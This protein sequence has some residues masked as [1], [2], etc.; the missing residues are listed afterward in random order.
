MSATQMQ[1]PRPKPFLR[2]PD[3]TQRGGPRVF[4]IPVHRNFADAL[5]N[6]I[7]AMHGSDRLALAR[8][9]IL[10]PNNRAAR[11]ITDAFVRRAEAGLLMPR[12]VAVGDVDGDAPGLALDP[13]DAEP[14]PPAIDR[15]LR[16]FVLARLVQQFRAET[17]ARTDAAEAL[18]LAANLATTID[19]LQ[20][21]DIDPAALRSLDVAESL[22]VHWQKSLEL[23]VMLLDRWPQELAALGC[24]DLVERR[25]RLLRRQAGAWREH[26]PASMIIAAGVT[27]SAVA[28]AGLLHVVARLP[29]GMVVLPGVDLASPDDEW[30]SIADHNIES[31]P[32]HHLR[33]LLDRMDV[34]RRDVVRWRWGDGRERKA[35]RARAVSNAFAPARFTGKWETLP[36]QLRRLRGVRIGTF[37]TAADEAQG[38]AIALRGALETSGKTAAL[39]TP[40]RALA[41]RVAAHLKRWGID[42]DDSAGRPLSLTPAG[43][44]ILGLADAANAQFAPA[45]LLSLLKHPLVRAG[46]ERLA[47]LSGARALDFA[48]R[49]PQPAPGLAGLAAFLEGSGA[50]TRS[51][52]AAAAPWWRETAS[53]L[54][55]IEAAFI[56]PLAD[57]ASLLEIMRATIEALAGDAAWAGPDGRAAGT[58]F[59]ALIA[60]AGKGPLDFG[61]DALAPALRQIMSEV[62]VRPPQGGHPRIAILGLL[63]ARLQ[64]ADLMILGGLNEGVWPPDASPDPWLAPRVR[65]ELGLGGLDRRV[66][67]SAHDLAMAL[68][69]REVLLTRSARDARSPT[70]ASRFVL[71]LQAMLGGIDRDDDIVAMATAIDAANAPP[72]LSHRPAPRPS[73]EYRPKIVSVTEVDRLKSDPFGFYARR[74]LRLRTL[75]PVEASPSPAWRGTLVHD[76]FDKWFKEDALDPAKLNDRVVALFSEPGMHPVLRALWQPRLTEAMTKM[77]ELVAEDAS[78]GRTVIAT[79]TQGSIVVA[80]VRL[81][82]RAD[83]I[84]RISDELAIVDYKTGAA[85]TAKTVA[86]GFSMQL[87]L[88]GLIADGGGFAGVSGLPTVFEY[89]SLQKDKD[90]RLGKR[91]SPLGSGKNRI[92]P[93][94]LIETTRKQFVIAAGRW[95]T[96]DDPFTALLHP[97]Y[98]RHNDYEQ[99]MR[100]QEWHGRG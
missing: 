24:I 84:D 75:D 3:A 92:E 16:R 34:A 55:P 79:E 69:G 50:R 87:G 89:W 18:R 74:I 42:A 78:A 51:A 60:A 11:A 56:D 45:A 57:F 83:R 47:W 80:G 8:T 40:D 100:K 36:A 98:A 54:G 9:T 35:V 19:T 67:L 28:V 12:M 64:S 71:R 91:V 82:G 44:L 41:T 61:P 72:Q 59:D 22:S 85:P 26:P 53:L 90:G 58:L 49:G 95:L 29:N 96:G 33:R 77:G 32:Q 86:A 48:L 13:A 27:T 94:D 17:G 31:H 52:R 88:L 25:N 93:G 30:N 6:G 10:L 99:L 65:M 5:A 76:V 21:E 15:M 68:G 7:L 97:D 43:T 2:M 37:A 38:I 23:F 39:V 70:I 63:E 4:T 66:G 1:L 62:A 73:A 20:A 46:E 14:V 81:E